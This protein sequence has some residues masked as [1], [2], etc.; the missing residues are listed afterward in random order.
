MEMVFDIININF[1]GKIYLGTGSPLG[2][3]VGAFAFAEG[4]L[5]FFI[6]IC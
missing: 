3:E 5:C 4:R 1:S 6:D 2:N